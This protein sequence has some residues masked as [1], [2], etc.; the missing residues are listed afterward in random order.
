MELTIVKNSRNERIYLLIDENDKV[1][2]FSTSVGVLKKKYG[3]DNSI[4]MDL[5]RE[6][7]N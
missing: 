4:S 5:D 2:D 1:V 6:I 7:S 3:Q